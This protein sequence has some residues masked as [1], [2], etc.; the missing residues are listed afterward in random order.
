MWNSH[1]YCLLLKYVEL[2]DMLRLHRLETK[3]KLSTLLKV[4]LPE[5]IDDGEFLINVPL[6]VR[7]RKWLVGC[8]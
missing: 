4:L 8:S 5:T 2:L 7:R 1:L 3:K 6:N